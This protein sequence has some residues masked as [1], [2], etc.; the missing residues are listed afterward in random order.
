MGYSIVITGAC[1]EEPDLLQVGC[2]GGS[3]AAGRAIMPCHACS[4]LY[5]VRSGAWAGGH[6]SVELASTC[7]AGCFMLL[8]WLYS[9]PG[10]ADHNGSSFS[11]GL[12]CSLAFLSRKS[13]GGQEKAVR[14][15]Q[16][17]GR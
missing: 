3:G 17:N 9:A 16:G 2:R 5:S 7:D 12:S 14:G 10:E 4:A 13:E 1:N 6:V 11:L 15:S 8:C